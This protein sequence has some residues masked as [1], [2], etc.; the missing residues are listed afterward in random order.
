MSSA[1]QYL[2]NVEGEKTA[3]IRALAGLHQIHGGHG[4][5]GGC[6]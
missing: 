2:T 1:L 4:G 6:G 5:F 3:V